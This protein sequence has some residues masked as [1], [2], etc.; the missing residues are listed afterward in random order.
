MKLIGLSIL[1]CA[2]LTEAVLLETVS[3]AKHTKCDFFDDIESLG[4]PPKNSGLCLDPNYNAA[5]GK[6][7]IDAKSNAVGHDI[8]PKLGNHHCELGTM[9]DF[10]AE[11]VPAEGDEFFESPKIRVFLDAKNGE[12][13]VYP[14]ETCPL[15]ERSIAELDLFDKQHALE[16]MSMGCHLPAEERVEQRP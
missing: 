11:L 4:V 16:I 1:L 15:I 14:N 10:T 3:Q 9:R 5:E 7:A 6:C 13:D 12:I 2:T 8:I